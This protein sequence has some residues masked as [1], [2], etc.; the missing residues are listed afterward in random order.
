MAYDV[1]E[2]SE[3]VLQA[4]GHLAPA[5]IAFKTHGKL[6]RE[7]SNAILFPTWFGSDHA[8]NQWLIGPDRAL[9][10]RRYF[11]IVVDFLGNGYSSSPSNAPPPADRT[12]FPHVTILD[13]VDLQRRLLRERFDIERLTLVVGRSMGAQIAY[14]WAARYPGSVDRVL[15]FCGSARTSPHNFVFLE[16]L[17]SAIITDPDWRDGE[18][19]TPP[20]AALRNIQIIFDGWA[21]SQAWYRRGLHLTSGFANIA[22][23][24]TRPAQEPSRDANDLLAQIWTWQHA[25]IS[26]NEAYRGDLEKALR[27]ITARAIVMPCR[28][29]LYFPPEDSENEV[30]HMRDAKL[31]VIPSVWGHRAGAPGTDPADI[32]FIDDAIRDLLAA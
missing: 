24:V 8:A 2:M 4:G 28:T 31:R 9:D 30:A 10:P 19:E 21:Y 6:S 23:F 25:D 18:Y 22:E 29:D 20:R 17:R 12:R 11:I 13:N 1:Y 15:P 14:Q 27:A 16:A 5:R 3:T 26:A 32:R 7:R